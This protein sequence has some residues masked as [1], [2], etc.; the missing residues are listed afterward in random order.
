M[1]DIIR[2][3]VK[4]MDDDKLFPGHLLA[5]GKLNYAKGKRPDVPCIFCAIKD[6]HPDVESLTVYEEK[7]LFICL[8]LY[9][10]NPGHL[11][12]IPKRHVESFE[13]LTEV[14]RNRIFKVVM[15][16]QQ[17]LNDLF[18]PTGYN[19]GYNQGQYSGASIS[20]IHVHVV[21]RYKSELGFIDIIGKTHIVVETAGNV[22][23]KIK[24]RI[25]D[26]ISSI[27]E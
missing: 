20:H 21:P 26:F 9:P 27:S 18:N 25:H 7:M 1:I 11:M 3:K 10:Y 17:L 24:S 5:V 15:N 2:R 6:Q 12:V 14:E 16:C 23:E 13:D 8:N 19:V 4:K 22:F